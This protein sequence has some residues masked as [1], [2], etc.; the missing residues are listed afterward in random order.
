ME[1][2]GVQLHIMR[3]NID[4]FCGNCR[5]T[6]MVL[7]AKDM[8]WCLGV[9]MVVLNNDTLHCILHSYTVWPMT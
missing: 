8:F 6:D 3:D 4:T 1:K 9:A 2:D 7:A 5:S